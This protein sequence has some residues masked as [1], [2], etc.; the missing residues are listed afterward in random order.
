MLLHLRI[1]MHIQLLQL[2]AWLVEGLV[3]EPMLGLLLAKHCHL[4][5]RTC[6]T[7]SANRLFLILK[8]MTVAADVRLVAVFAHWALPRDGDVVSRIIL[9]QSGAPA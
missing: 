3:T 8:W 1:L 5:L 9:E 2:V 7:C 6:C 4:R